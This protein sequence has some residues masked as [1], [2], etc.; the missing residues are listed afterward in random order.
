MN[1]I[2]HRVKQL[3]IYDPDSGRFSWRE[4]RYRT[5]KAG[6]PAGSQHKRTGYVEIG[7]DG[8]LHLA[9]RIAWLYMTGDFPIG[10]IDHINGVR[11]D[12]RWSNLRSV[13][14][15]T[16]SINR[17]RALSKCGFLG[18]T[19]S[20]S[21]FKAAIRFQGRVKYLGTYPTPEIAHEIYKTARA[22]YYP[23]SPVALPTQRPI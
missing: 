10:P 23:D 17:Q 1:L 6:T 21:G 19:K 12:N 3:I 7:I 11:N 2:S 4:D 22:T 8:K 5:I 20:G 16:N 18:V 14:R 9:H 15:K 13:T